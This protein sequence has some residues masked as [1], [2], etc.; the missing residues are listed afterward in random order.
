MPHEGISLI[1]FSKSLRFSKKS[2][3]LPS[4]FL[5]T[6]RGSGCSKQAFNFS[7]SNN[8]SDYPGCQIFQRSKCVG[9]AKIGEPVTRF[10][11][12]HSWSIS[13]V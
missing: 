9:Y 7:F 12:V 3:E 10:K 2:I 11:A 8:N 5:R 1:L 13:I 6:S 4:N